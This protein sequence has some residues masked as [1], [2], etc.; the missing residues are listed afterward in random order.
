MI[1]SLN[2]INELISALMIGSLFFRYDPTINDWMP[3]DNLSTSILTKMGVR[4]ELSV[5]PGMWNCT[6][7]IQRDIAVTYS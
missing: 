3:M 7:W 5:R 2:V 6:P 1:L 4:G